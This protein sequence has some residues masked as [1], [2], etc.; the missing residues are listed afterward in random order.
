[1]LNRNLKLNLKVFDQKVEELNLRKG[2]GEGMVIAGQLNPEVVA[3]TADL[4]E[5]VGFEDFF[6]KFPNKSIDVGIAEQNLV[7]VASGMASQGKIPFVGS[8]AIFNPG[9]NWEQIRTTIAYNNQNVKIV[10]THA[11]LNVGP[12]GGSHQMLEDIALMRVMPNMKVI[13]PCDYHEAKR[14]AIL[15]MKTDGPIYIRL[16]REKSPVITTENSPLEIGKMYPIYMTPKPYADI[17]ILA[18]GPVLYNALIAAKEA[19]NLGI[20]IKVVNVPTIKPLDEKTLI[21]IAHETK[22]I[23]TVEEAQMNGG[24]GGAVSEFLAK[25]FPVMMEFIAVQDEF[26]QSGTDKELKDF[27]GLGSK[28]ILGAIK[29]LVL[30]KK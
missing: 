20:A 22:A 4:K 1:M 30:R 17:A 11:G 26:G 15:A 28:D 7:T 27:Y 29:R 5:S 23:I 6:K 2:F 3:L 24:L 19:E 13:S 8:Y 14:A 25:H 9:R 10:G 18:T 16:P 21:E 12:D